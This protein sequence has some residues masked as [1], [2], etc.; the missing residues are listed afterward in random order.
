VIGLHVSEG[1][2]ADIEGTGKGKWIFCYHNIFFLWMNSHV[3]G[4]SR[5][6]G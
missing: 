1:Y 5:R 6:V 4:R 2:A 3:F